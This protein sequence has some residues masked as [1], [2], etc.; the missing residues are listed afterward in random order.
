MV[1]VVSFSNLKYLV[2]DRIL[3]AGVRALTTAMI[4]K[5]RMTPAGLELAMSPVLVTGLVTELS[6][7][8][9]EPPHL[10]PSGN[11]RSC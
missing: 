1:N 3:F 7:M 8:S 10:R 5:R 2:F 4:V 11:L 9:P 6:L